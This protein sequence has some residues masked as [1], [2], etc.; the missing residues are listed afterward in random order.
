MAVYDKAH[1]LARSL[2]ESE[3][4]QEYK[5]LKDQV[6]EQERN[7]VLIK[8]YKRIQF[9]LQAQQLSGAQLDENKLQEFQKLADVLQF[10]PEVHKFLT[11]EYRLHQMLGDVYKIIGDAV[12]VNLGFLQE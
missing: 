1:E 9:E 4:Y 8:D 12:D 5:R 2:Q 11:A 6:F 10:N 3:E 7:R